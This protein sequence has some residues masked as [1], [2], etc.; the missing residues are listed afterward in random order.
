MATNRVELKS[1]TN[2]SFPDSD[3]SLG[4]AK[5]QEMPGMPGAAKGKQR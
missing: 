5:K 1:V 3:F 4:T 2:V